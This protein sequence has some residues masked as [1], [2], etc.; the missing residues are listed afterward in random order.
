M[1]AGGRAPT[2]AWPPGLPSDVGVLAVRHPG[3]EDRLDDPFATVL[4]A[5]ANDIA[6]AL[7]GLT[8]HRPLDCPVYGYTGD[9]D[10]DVSPERMSRWADMTHG[11]FR[12][13]VLPGG[14]FYLRPEEAALPAD[15]S[16]VLVSLKSPTKGTS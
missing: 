15:L 5:L 9:D 8:R 4:E 14:H 10:H 1:P 7:G 16:D 6:D 2:R 12:L 3:R 13:R 11:A